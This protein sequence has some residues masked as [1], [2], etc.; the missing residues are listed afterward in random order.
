MRKVN[1]PQD[2]FWWRLTHLDPAIYKGIVVAVVALLT[3]IGVVISPTIP[4]SVVILIVAVMSMVQAL[5]TK[6]S[7]TPNAKVIAYLDDPLKPK[8]IL[9]GEAITT[10]TDAAIVKAARDAG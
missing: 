9:P 6:T 2:T 4:D 7:V 3:S 1:E 5:W 8:E 10:A